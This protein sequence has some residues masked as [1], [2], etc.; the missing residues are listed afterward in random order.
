MSHKLPMIQSDERLKR[1]V[2]NLHH[3]YTGK[4]YVINDSDRHVSLQSLDAVSILT[5]D[6]YFF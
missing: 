1:L 5:H 3:T 6:E 4:K 2:N